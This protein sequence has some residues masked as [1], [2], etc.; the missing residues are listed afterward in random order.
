[1]Q[2]DVYSAGSLGNHF[3]MCPA[4]KRLQGVVN[5]VGRHS[6]LGVVIGN[7]L[8]TEFNFTLDTT[9]HG[10]QYAADDNSC[11]DTSYSTA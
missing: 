6:A 7:V 10:N 1:M 4:D 3:L 11:V 9:K 5:L 2:R 8:S